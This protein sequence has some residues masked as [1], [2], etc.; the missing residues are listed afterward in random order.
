MSVRVGLVN[1]DALFERAFARTVR[2]YGEQ[3]QREFESPLW[4]WPRTTRR[5]GGRIAGSPRDLVDTGA[6]KRSQQPPQ[7]VGLNARI[8]WTADHAA[9]VFAGVVGKDRQSKPA[10]NL[11]LYVAERFNFGQSFLEAL[12]P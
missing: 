2:A 4:E 9:E 11:P 8:T 5:S 7:V 12:E 6:L 10:R 1:L 3:V